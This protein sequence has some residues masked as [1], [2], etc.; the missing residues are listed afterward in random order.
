MNNLTPKQEALASGAAHYFT[1]KPCLRGHISNR[2]AYSGNCIECQ[3]EHSKSDKGRQTR[4]RLRDKPEYQEQAKKYS[5][6]YHAENRD[7][8]LAKMRERNPEYYEKNR[9]RVKAQT[10]RYQSENSA[11]RNAYKIEWMRLRKANDP[12]YAALTIMRKMV[13]RT[14]DRIKVNRR[15][16]GRTVQ[17]LGYTAL[18]FKFHIETLFTDGMTWGNHGQW[19]VDHIKPLSRFNLTDPEQRRAANSLDNLQPLWAAENMSKGAKFE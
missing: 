7:S 13:T 18:E 6:A 12:Q 3:R 14:C 19:H 17:A 10:S 15:E 9:D 5:A 8:C 11:K 1:G 4:A 16:I 2:S